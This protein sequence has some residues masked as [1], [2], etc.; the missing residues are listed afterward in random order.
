MMCEHCEARVQK[1]LEGV[2]GV[3]SASASHKE[4][5][6]VVRADREI[7]EDALRQAV[8]AQDYEVRGISRA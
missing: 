6:A 5:V 7:P 4:G 1:A 3:I 8:T 2:P